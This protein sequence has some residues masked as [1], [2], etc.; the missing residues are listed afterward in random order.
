[1]SESNVMPVYK[2]TDPAHVAIP[3]TF[4]RRA[5]VKLSVGMPLVMSIRSALSASSLRSHHWVWY[6]VFVTR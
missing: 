3:L 5:R 6:P 2:R 1:M 4:T